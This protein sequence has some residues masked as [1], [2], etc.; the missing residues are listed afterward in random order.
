MDSIY[1]C[2]YNGKGDIYQSSQ[3]LLRTPIKYLLGFPDTNIGGDQNVEHINLEYKEGGIH[4]G[5]YF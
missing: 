4:F 5:M 3:K 2:L 1:N